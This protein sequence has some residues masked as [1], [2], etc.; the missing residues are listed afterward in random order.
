M[1]CKAWMAALAVKGGTLAER[2]YPAPNKK[3]VDDRQHFHYQLWLLP[4]AMP[5][6]LSKVFSK[7]MVTLSTS[8]MCWS[9]WKSKAPCFP[10]TLKDPN[11]KIHPKL[12]D[13]S[14]TCVSRPPFC[15]GDK[16][17]QA[18]ISLGEKEMELSQEKWFIMENQPESAGYQERIHQVLQQEHLKASSFQEWLMCS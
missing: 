9:A 7:V 3:W 10:F 5:P 17:F 18:L 13:N 2:Q 1:D 8:C 11:E 6:I 12:I 15:S 16:W 4:A 14:T